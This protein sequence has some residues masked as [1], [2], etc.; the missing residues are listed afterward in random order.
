MVHNYLLIAYTLCFVFLLIKFL[1]KNMGYK[2][3]T[4]STKYNNGNIIKISNQYHT[5]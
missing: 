2:L 1:D 4:D 5:N 3:L